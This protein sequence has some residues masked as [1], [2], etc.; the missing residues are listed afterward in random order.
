MGAANQFFID[1]FSFLRY[2]A[3]LQYFWLPRRLNLNLAEISNIKISCN[4]D[5]DERGL[6]HLFLFVP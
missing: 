6:N 1:C 2:C 4:K 5:G 3:I